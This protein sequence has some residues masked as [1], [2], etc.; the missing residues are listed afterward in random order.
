VFFPFYRFYLK[1]F[2]RSLIGFIVEIGISLTELDSDWIDAMAVEGW[3]LGFC[4]RFVI[5]MPDLFVT[6]SK[7]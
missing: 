7:V 5:F 2:S 4:I 3:G 6:G 1:S